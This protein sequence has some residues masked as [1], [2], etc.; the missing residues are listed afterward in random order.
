[1]GDNKK[2]KWSDGV[3]GADASAM[4][5]AYTIRTVGASDGAIWFVTSL[6]PGFSPTVTR[7]V[8]HA[9]R[10]VRRISAERALASF[11][12]ARGSDC[13]G[14]EV[15]PLDE[16]SAM[17]DNKNTKSTA[18]AIEDIRKAAKAGELTYEDLVGLVITAYEEAGANATNL[19]VKDAMVGWSRTWQRKLGAREDA[20]EFA[21]NQDED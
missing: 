4:H 8:R 1:M 5:A 10:Y 14:F 2:A 3:D 21:S 15:V 20:A 18:Q 7:D 6:R 16:V 12:D 11:V 17:G 13:D 19:A 9:K